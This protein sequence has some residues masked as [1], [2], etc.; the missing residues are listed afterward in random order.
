MKTVP[1]SNVPITY[2]PNPNAADG[3]GVTSGGGAPDYIDYPGPPTVVPPAL[4]HIV[5]DINGQQWM[6]YNGGWN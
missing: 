1:E 2:V 5:V 3:Q 4:V 6:Y